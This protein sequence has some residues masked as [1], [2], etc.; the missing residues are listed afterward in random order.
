M[1]DVPG[2]PRISRG[3]FARHCDRAKAIVFLVD[4]IDFMVQKDQVSTA[5]NQVHKID[6]LSCKA[7]AALVLACSVRWPIAA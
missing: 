5:L 6:M 3:V 4:S 7:G 2:H 1:V